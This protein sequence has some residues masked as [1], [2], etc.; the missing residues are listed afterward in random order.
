VAELSI[1][2]GHAC[3]VGALV[4]FAYG[5]AAGIYGGHTG[6]RRWVDSARR[7]ETRSARIAKLVADSAEGKRP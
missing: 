7:A 4:A 2:A 3:L 1:D 5:A 6:D